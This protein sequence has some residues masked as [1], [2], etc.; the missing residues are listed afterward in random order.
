MRLLSLIFALAIVAWL[1]YTYLNSGQTI[2]M[3]GDKTVKQQTQETIQQAR[4]AAGDLQNTLNE[5]T[6]QLEK[7]E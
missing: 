3:D 1:V 2:N 5:K 4:D 6:K 7:S